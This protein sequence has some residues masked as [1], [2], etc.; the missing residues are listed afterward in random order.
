MSSV[1]ERQDMFEFLGLSRRARRKVAKPS[2]ER[3]DSCALLARRWTS[4]PYHGALRTHAYKQTPNPPPLTLTLSLSYAQVD[5]GKTM[6]EQCIRILPQHGIKSIDTLLLTHAHAD[7][8]HGL[9]DIR[10]FQQQVT[11]VGGGGG[12]SVGG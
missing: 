6:R 10:D 4:A 2:R 7:A 11:C 8:I 9:D 12:V 3:V 5:A 1:D